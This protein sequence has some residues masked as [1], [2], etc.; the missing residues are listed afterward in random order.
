M[1]TEK[2]RNKRLNANRGYL[3][4]K[5]KLAG[6]AALHNVITMRENPVA[7]RRKGYKD[8]SSKAME[9]T[10]HLRFLARTWIDK[11]GDEISELAKEKYFIYYGVEDKHDDLPTANEIRK[12]GLEKISGLG[13]S[14]V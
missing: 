12:Y 2:E 11:D 13:D 3:R 10:N 8:R 4:E 6:Y 14:L 1:I 9:I 7:L 5:I